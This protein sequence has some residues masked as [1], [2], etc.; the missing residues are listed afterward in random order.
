MPGFFV[1]VIGGK[2]WLVS[3]TPFMKG[4]PGSGIFSIAMRD[5]LNGVIVGGNYENSTDSSNNLAITS[6]GA[7]TWNIRPGL[8]GYRSAVT[9]VD[10]RTLIA[11]GTNGTD[12]SLDSG[13]LWKNISEK[14]LNTVSSLGRN[15]T[16]GAGPNGFVVKQ[17]SVESDMPTSSR[18]TKAPFVHG[19]VGNV[20]SLTLSR[21]EID[22]NCVPNN[23]T[24]SNS[25]LIDVVAVAVDPDDR[26]EYVYSIN[27]GKI[28]GTGAN[29]K[30]DLSGVPRGTY[31]ITAGVR[32]S[33]VLGP[34]ILGKTMTETVVIK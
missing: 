18:R 27:A 15:F 12:V 1:R 7:K 32:Q 5:A 10:K 31:A 6:D 22:L 8:S 2:T 23:S 9:F 34:M 26:L 29:V 33:T 21:G 28:I 19:F 25:G 13:R 14:N 16:F 20:T 3:D 4:S 11:V 17:K 24:C 30:W